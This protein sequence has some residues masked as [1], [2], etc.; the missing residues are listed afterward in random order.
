MTKCDK[1]DKLH[2]LWQ[3]P[4]G[5]FSGE[6]VK[7]Y[8]NDRSPSFP[9]D[10]YESPIKFRNASVTSNSE[11]D[12]VTPT[13]QP[14]QSYIDME[15]KKSLEA[16]TEAEA[17]AEAETEAETEAESEELLVFTNENDDKDKNRSNRVSESS[18]D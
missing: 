4:V 3:E 8:V 18:K 11:N 17:E 2:T 16:E 13:N 10:H 1:I 9:L 7:L 6:S 14:S 15:G 12:L 5:T